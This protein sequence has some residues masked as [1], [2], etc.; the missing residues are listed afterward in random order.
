MRV[1]LVH[2]Y[3][4]KYGGAERVLEALLDV[5]P[6]APVFTLLYEP[7]TTSARIRAAKI[8][9]SNL[10][11]HRW[12]RL[13]I[14]RA[15]ALMPYHV[16]QFDLAGYDVVI[17][18]AHS[19]IKGIITQPET[20]HICYCHTPTRYLW[21]QRDEALQHVGRLLERFLPL[22]ATFFRAWDYNAAQRVDHFI[23][24]SHTVAQ[25]IKKFYRRTARVIYP[26]VDIERFKPTPIPTNAPYLIISRL[27]PHKRVDLA[28]GAVKRTN[29][30]LIVAGI[31][32]SRTALEHDAG[33]SV[34]FLGF[35]SDRQI[36]QL[37]K[38]SRALIFPQE[39]D[40]GITAVEALAS[41]RPV[42]A[43]QA[44]GAQEILSSQ[45][46]VFFPEPTISSLTRALEREQRRIWDRG[47]L[48]QAA[49]RFARRRF[50]NE[51]RSAVYEYAPLVKK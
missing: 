2:D 34:K 7:K 22:G 15:R 3:L 21:H 32:S 29:A 23:A 31:G 45:T 6:D 38:K 8:I 19:F 13:H 44:G 11:R 4:V 28:I 24:N 16:E 18:S 51:V 49:R 42:I 26:P 48:V 41:G 12:A 17:S 40:F 9:P 27:E 50:Q 46:G 30:K 47:A 36:P 43:Y 25:R 37:Y 5:F 39:E 10:N 1:A 33:P 14:N 20:V 35:V